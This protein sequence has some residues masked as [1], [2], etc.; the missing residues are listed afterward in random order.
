MVLKKGTEDE[1][2]KDTCEK[3]RK[4]GKL[5]K[6]QFARLL[7]IFGGRFERALKVV[8]ENRV[9]HYTFK[10]SGREIWIVVGKEREYQIL[11]RAGYCSCDDFY[12][13]VMSGEVG[14]CYHLIAQRICE[15]VG[16]VE[17][18]EEGDEFYEAL[19][20]EWRRQVMAIG[21]TRP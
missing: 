20:V 21:R 13:H 14:V 11:P 3:A 19:M 5:S 6:R 18:V 12:F 10:P 4:E 7:E 1:V 8:E 2:L 9:K 16:T 15:A 17:E